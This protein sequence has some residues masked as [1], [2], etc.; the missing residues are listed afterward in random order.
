MLCS[1]PLFIKFGLWQYNKAEQKQALQAMYD[2]ALLS[3]PVDLPLEFSDVGNWRYRQVKVSGEYTPEHQI[4]LDNQVEQERAGYHVITPLRI[5]RS[6]KYVLVDRGWVVANAD[7]SILPEIETPAGE[8]AI[9]G[10]LWLPSEK[11]YSLEAAGAGAGGHEWQL[12]WQ[13]MD[14]SRYK[15]SVPFQV[16]PM[17]VRLDPES[18]A[19]GYS[20]Q[21]PR[22]AERITTH[23]GYAYQWFGFAV[24]AVLIW[25]FVSFRR[26]GNEQ[27]AN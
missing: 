15:Q 24:A 12:L 18:E 27:D 20:R 3:E 16:L 25:V 21:W 7:R 5:S 6:E 2:R 1:I 11:F 22:P 23:I 19:G 4:L 9:V 17:V 13:N 14:M 8:Q 26:Q 10:H